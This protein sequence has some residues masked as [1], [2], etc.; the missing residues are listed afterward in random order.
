MPIPQKLL[1]DLDGTLVDSLTDIATAMNTV[2]TRHHF[3]AHPVEAY[4][5]F[6]G[7]GMETLVR[8]VLPETEREDPAR[9]TTLVQQMK[10][11]YADQWYHASRP[12]NGI[13]ELLRDLAARGCPLGVLSNKPEEFTVIMVEHFFPDIPFDVIR[14]ARPGVP[15]KPAPEAPL[16]IAADWQSP[17]S[18]IL[19]IGDTRTDIET[20]INAGM[21]TIG[22][23]WGFRDRTELAAAGA[24]WIIDHP[25]DLI[26]IALAEQ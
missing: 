5:T 25:A 20:G 21:P 10:R 1:F 11:V 13:P 17:P 15:V 23:T 14:G 4:R 26:G 12:Y 2:L 7:D 8:R 19:Y 6:V 22:V 18:E 3:P 24:T 16:E 9:I